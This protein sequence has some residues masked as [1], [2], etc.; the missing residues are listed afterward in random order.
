M[1]TLDKW[2]WVGKPK[3]NPKICHVCLSKHVA[4]KSDSGKAYCMECWHDYPEGFKT[5]GWD[6]I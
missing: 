1:S 5:T 2:V 4:I 3:P 6:F